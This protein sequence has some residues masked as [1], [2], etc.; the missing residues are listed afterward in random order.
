VS[1]GQVLE[2]DVSYMNIKELKYIITIAE[3]QSITNAAKKLFLSQ[4]TLSHSLNKIEEDIGTLLFDR[5]TIPLKLTNAGEV[6]M[7]TGQKL[8]ALNQELQQQIQDIADFK[9]GS[10]TIGLTNLAERYYFPLVM[11]QFRKKYPGIQIITK[12]DSLTNLENLLLKNKV[13][14]AIIL[15]SNNPLLEYRPLFNM[16]ILLALPIDHP[17]CKK[18]DYQAGVYPEIDLMELADEEFIILQQGRRIRETAIEV[19]HKAG[20]NPNIVLEVSN[21]DAA[22]ALVAEGYG[23]T[24]VLDVATYYL[25]RQHK[26]A[27]FRIKGESLYQTMCLGHLKNKYLPKLVDSFFNVEKAL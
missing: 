17:I 11:P 18:Y 2:Q 8:L 10:L 3:E 19:C 27:Y 22:H 5:S 24:F 14:F 16:D 12:V 6:V 4:S 9:R 1:R 15:P 7:E 21:L 23:V 20:F 25:S 26:V 13:D